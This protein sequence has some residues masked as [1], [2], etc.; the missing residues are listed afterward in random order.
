MPNNIQNT[1]YGNWVPKKMLFMQAGATLALI[2]GANLAPWFP[3]RVFLGIAALLSLFFFIYY[4]YAFQ[5]FSYEGGCVSG[6]ILDY[7]LTFVEWDGKGRGLDIGCGSGALSARLAKKY[8]EAEIAAID[9]WD[10]KWDYG[11]E[12]CERNAKI[13]GV[14]SNITF[15]KASASSL[16]FENESF[17]LVVSN[18]CFHE[19]MDAKDKRDVVKEALRVL[20]KGGAFVFHDLFFS[21]R[22]YGEPD[23][24]LSE[25]RKLGLKEVILSNSSKIPCIPRFLRL[26]SMLGRIGLLY[27]K[28]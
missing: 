2:V 28:K 21:R 23:E 9:Y 7:L 17:S 16:P 26:P 13:E 4:F 20:K 24:M 6:K 14:E 3:V 25:L 5:A 22:L 8:P 11:K 15:Q 12:Q 10:G 18:F 1:D 27:G 19:V